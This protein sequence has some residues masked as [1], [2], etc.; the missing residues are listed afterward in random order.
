MSVYSGGDAMA[1][2]RQLSFEADEMSARGVWQVPDRD[3]LIRWFDNLAESARTFSG[4]SSKSPL[5]NLPEL[6]N[7]VPNVATSAFFQRRGIQTCLG[8][9]QSGD[10]YQLIDLPPPAR[11]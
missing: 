5:A 8:T 4:L 2:A 7:L 1:A 10:Q 3:V 9:P 6:G 11:A